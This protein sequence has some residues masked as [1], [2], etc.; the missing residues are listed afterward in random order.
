[1]TTRPPTYRRLAAVALLLAVVLSAASILLMPRFDGGADAQLAAI[2]ASG[3]AGTVS[4]LAFTLAQ[5]PM[6]IGF[7]VV[8]HLVGRRAAVLAAIGGTLLVLGCFGHAVHGGMSN[9][10][11]AMAADPA[12]RDAHAAVI[13]S[14]SDGAHLPFM[15]AGLAGTVLG[16]VVLAIGMLRARFAP[17]WVPWALLAWVVVEFVGSGLVEWAAY[18]SLLLFAGAIAG[19]AVAVWRSDATPGEDPRQRLAPTAEQRAPG[20][21]PA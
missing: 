6:A 12:N 10:M 11:L 2:A 5:L 15:I 4:A 1:M 8:A 7:V 20:T 21:S 13:A 18:A 14:A 3:L 9:V 17:A 16:I 19:L